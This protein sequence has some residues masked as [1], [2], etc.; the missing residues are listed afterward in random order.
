MTTADILGRFL[1]H[2]LMT[3]DQGA[4]GEFYKKVTGW[5]TQPF[6]ADS[7]Y[8]LWVTPGGPR[9]GSTVLSEDAQSAGT[10]P[11]WL[12][13]IGTPDIESTVENAK[14]LGGRVITEISDIPEVGRYAV[15]ADPQGAVFGVYQPASADGEAPTGVGD[16]SWHELAT[17]DQEA[18]WSFYNELFGWAEEG[19]H[20]M[21]PM[22]TYQL[23]G[24]G[25]KQVGGIYTLSSDTSASPHWLCYVN[26]ASAAEAA[27]AAKAA[28]GQV[29]NGPMEVPG[30]DWVAQVIDPQGAVFAV[31]ESKA[32]AAKPG[33]KP[34]KSKPSSKP[35][36]KADS[37]SKPEDVTASPAMEDKE[38]EA[39]APAAAPAPKKAKQKPAGRASQ[40]GAAG[41]KAKGKAAAKSKAPAAAKKAVSKQAASQKKAAAKK[42]SAAVKKKPAA[43]KKA[44]LK[45]KGS[46]KAKTK[47][48]TRA[49][50]KSAAGKKKGVAAKKRR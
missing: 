24:Q 34:K 32:K 7:D 20:D 37:A 44:A 19:R 40:A 8:S 50:A 30:G 9:G 45:K 16:F 23:F 18:A 17:T 4:A 1:W 15:L 41:S 43:P 3:T 12:V 22:G 28:G 14:R 13:H 10:P 46:A 27:E 5:T 36:V 21:G 33:K 47:G 38:E 11:H 48:Q 26:V 25:G 49:V 31:H 2:D 29:V 6:D 42:K 39:E 35:A